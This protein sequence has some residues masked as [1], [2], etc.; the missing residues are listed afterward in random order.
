MALTFAENMRMIAAVARARL[1]P[2]SSPASATAGACYDDLEAA[3]EDPDARPRARALRPQRLQALQRLV[4]A[5]RRR[6]AA[7]AAR[8]EP[9]PVRHG[10]RTRLPD[11]RRRV[12]HRRPR[13]TTPRPELVVAGA[14]RALAEHGEGFAITA[15]YG[16]VVLP[17]EANDP[18][19]A[20]RLADQRMYENKQGAR[21]SAGE[22]SSGVLLRALS[23]RHPK[24]GDHVGR[25]RGARR[26]RRATT[27][28]RRDE[29]VARTRLAGA[30]HEIGK[31]AIPDA[32]LEKPGPLT[33]D[34]W[35]FVR[36]HTLI[37]E[38]ILHAAHGACL[39]RRP[40]A[41]ELTSASTARATR[42]VSRARTSRSSRA[43]SSSATRSTR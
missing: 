34:E 37:G 8:R 16:A 6:R 5:S 19:D 27:R 10:P 32:I 18:Q 30:L 22:Q 29:E 25:C 12:L 9:R 41:L 2:T 23:E 14:A 11:G 26:G 7:R 1:A 13:T 43:S 24:L 35:T 20:L 21:L 4:R 40:R 39:R 15:A 31:M 33:D 38:R 3:L 17:D 42:T 36:G 28:P